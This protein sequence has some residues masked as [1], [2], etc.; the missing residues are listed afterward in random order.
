MFGKFAA[1]KWNGSKRTDESKYKIA[2]PENGIDDSNSIINT[3]NGEK[4]KPAVYFFF[5]TESEY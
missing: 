3:V 1:D 2:R 5:S 4:I